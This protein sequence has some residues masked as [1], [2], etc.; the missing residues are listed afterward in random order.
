MKK[1]LLLLLVLIGV[2]SGVLFTSP[3][4]ERV[5]VPTANLILR[6]ALPEHRVVLERFEPAPGSLYAAGT[7]DG[8]IRFEAEGPVEWFHRRIALRYR[9]RSGELAVRGK[10]Y[11]V[12][13]DLKGE[14]SGKLPELR[15]NGA[16]MGFGGE[17]SYRFFLKTTGLEEIEATARGA[18]VEEILTFAGKPPYALGALDLEVSLPRVERNAPEGN[19][20]FT[21]RNGRVDA[22]L[23]HR[24]FGID[25][26]PVKGYTLDGT[27]RTERGL[28]RGTARL[29]SP[30]VSLELKDF[31]SDRA[32]RIFKSAYR[33][34]VP[35]LSRLK[36]LTGRELYGPFRSG[37]EF[38]YD[39]KRKRLQL[40]GESPSFEGRTAFFYENGHLDLTLE[41][42]GIPQL[43]AL[44]GEP[45]L[46]KRGRLEG[47][48]R[49]ELGRP[50][51]A[52]YRFLARG[53]W[54]RDELR[55]LTGN[56][57]GMLLDFTLR[58]RGDLKKEVVTLQAD[59]RNSLFD[60]NL[61]RLRYALDGGAMEGDYRLTVEDLGRMKV[62]EGKGVH[63]PFK[64]EG[65]LRYLP[66]KKLLKVEGRSGSLGGDLRF[67]YAGKRVNVTL[68]KVDGNRF[69]ALLGQKP[70]L[71]G[72]E[73]NGQVKI[74][75]LEKR[76]GEFALRVSGILD[77]KRM[78][79]LY[80]IDPGKGF[81]VSLSG[82]GEL[83]GKK[84]F[85]GWELRSA[86]L[87][88]Q[89]TPCEVDLEAGSCAG[90]YRLT[91]PEL[92]KLKAFTGRTYH[93]P[94]RL[95]GK[96]LHRKRLRLSGAGRE[97][98]GSL[99][100][101]L[102]GE[103][104]RT[105][106]RE[107][108]AKSLSKMLGYPEM[109][110]GRLSGDLRYDLAKET[111]TFTAKMPTAR[112]VSGPMTMVASRLLRYDLGKELFRDVTLDARIRGAE[113]VFD[114]LARSK[115]LELNV[116]KGKLDRKRG[117]IDAVVTILDRGK[118]Y[119]IRIK[120]PLERPSVTPLVTEDLVRKA[121]KEIRRR[122]IDKKIEKA[123]PKELRGEGG[124][125]ADFFKKLF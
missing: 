82:K 109:I 3:G 85:S 8:T 38:Y 27:F 83:K 108:D 102:E 65:K 51:K 25:L 111:G 41:K 110:D 40:K 72:S 71:K 34:E 70:F 47:T 95:E 28:L 18:R 31:R 50:I 35:E 19:V 2:G 89:I 46:V 63:L 112:L 119:R 100:Y 7:V 20:R 29:K 81:R 53:S 6:Y 115:R 24:E 98:G 26:P 93:G 54:D 45:P 74:S 33:L 14:A 32:L 59:Y 105:R 13:I 64:A 78:K 61:P 92:S 91:V 22:P 107:I 80:G 103:R 49:L 60:L 114:F 118:R 57:P 17:L 96:I 23:L 121:E 55:K 122:K 68:N 101:L 76:R 77:R 36:R 124:P 21:V 97:L 69:M 67:L 73:L 120:G 62:L 79:K 5:L 52:E 94:L 99:E 117:R 30:L 43:L 1:L 116:R 56:D 12:T 11:P 42:V 87:Q 15:V 125:V 104:L 37:G 4:R 39:R 106:V 86:P 66:V 10:R 48:A 16:G 84:V 123:I 75:N 58:S 44:T 9:I 113:V 88:L 90:S